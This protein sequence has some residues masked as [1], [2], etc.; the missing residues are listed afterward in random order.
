MRGSYGGCIVSDGRIYVYADADAKNRPIGNLPQW[1]DLLS[2]GDVFPVEALDR[3]VCA[4]APP[5]L[6]RASRS[7]PASQRI[8][9]APLCRFSRALWTSD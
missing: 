8:H 3:A 2:D 9:R 1:D 5:M 6:A 7:P 4:D